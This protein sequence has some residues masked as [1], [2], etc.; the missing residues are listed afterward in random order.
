M[1]DCPVVFKAEILIQPVPLISFAGVQ[2]RQVPRRQKPTL[3][4]TPLNSPSSS[5]ML[6]CPMSLSPPPLSSIMSKRRIKVLAIKSSVARKN[7][8]TG[9]L[10]RVFETPKNA[11]KFDVVKYN[12]LQICLRSESA[13]A[14]SFQ[15]SILVSWLILALLQL[16]FIGSSFPRICLYDGS[17][18]I[19]NA[20]VVAAQHGPRFPF[21]NTSTDHNKRY[22]RTSLL[23]YFKGC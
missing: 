3:S 15:L 5:P 21:Q 6:P 12:Q 17:L 10:Q 23:A 16:P 9:L 18:L 11:V 20:L 7:L 4:P 14:S 13:P 22:L 1:I 19:N 2:C 8:S